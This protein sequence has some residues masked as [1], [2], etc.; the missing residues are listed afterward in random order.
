M[1]DYKRKLLR[2]RLFIMKKIAANFCGY[3]MVGDDKYTYYVSDNIVTLLPAQ[4]DKRKIYE[5]FDKICNRDIERPEYLFGEDNGGMIAIL[6]NGKFST[7]GM[8]FSPAIKFA[9]PIIIKASGNAQGFFSMMTEPWEKFHAITFYGG[10]IN[11][12][13]DPGLAIQPLDVDQ[14][15][16]YDGA[17]EIRMRPWSDYTRSIDFRIGN[18]KVT[19]TFSIRQDGG[20][21]GIEY[22]GAYNLGNLNSFI[23]FSFE[24][25]QYFD[26]I[27][28]C[29]LIAK[30]LIA[31]LTSQNN[32]YFEGY[33]SQKNSDDKF[34]ETGICKIF[35]HYD[36]YSMRKC[37]NVIP[38]FSIFDYIPKLI[39]G[40]VNGKADTLLELLPENNEMVSRISI[41]NVQDL[42]TALEVT[43]HL[44]DK[45]S[46]EKDVLIEEI[47]KNIKKTIADFSKS[48]NEIDVNK[49]TTISSAFQYLDY[50]LKQ[51]IF[52]LYN[53]NREV[54]DAIV[55]KWVLPQVNEANIA[56]FVK[57]RNN[58]THSG[59]VEWGDSAKLY[60][61]LL[62]IV[63]AGFFKYI[64]LP[65]EIIICTLMQI[66]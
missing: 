15:L 23:R 6:R 25:A 53:E 59:T 19:L 8:G 13:C 64:G 10:N 40:I 29:Y 48:H 44:D 37:H 38:I 32:V 5:S 12:L 14:Y 7:S 55:S 17:R 57:L 45:R 54:A 2:S 46:R 21:N 31:I 41:K 50:T 34:F 62:A 51:K 49:E 3:L 52:T 35:D 39:E 47:K 11:A 28:E 18:E 33:L 42:C 27:Q 58:K 43:Y 66:F 63:Y 9:T 26:R 22:Q 30:K 56:S 36:N 4:S 1:T 20:T 24:N 60:A 61:P 16:K 65:D